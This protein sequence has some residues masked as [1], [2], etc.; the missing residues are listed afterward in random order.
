[1]RR[2]LGF[3]DPFDEFESRGSSRRDCH[4]TVLTVDGTADG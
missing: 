3:K 4:D 1:M 2:P